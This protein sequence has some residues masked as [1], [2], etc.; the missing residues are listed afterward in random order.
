MKMSSALLRFAEGP[1]ARQLPATARED[2]PAAWNPKPEPKKTERATEQIMRW[3]D[4]GG[5]VFEAPISNPLPQPGERDTARGMDA[6][7]GR[8]L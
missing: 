1:R 3:E 8:R 4:D 6:L 7:H 5:P 2:A